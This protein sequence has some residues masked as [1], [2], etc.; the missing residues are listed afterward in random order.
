[1]NGGDERRNEKRLHCD[2]VIWLTD[3]NNKKRYHGMIHDLSSSGVA[4]I[5]NAGDSFPQQGQQIQVYFYIPRIESGEPY[6]VDRRGNVCR[7]I[8]LDKFVRKVHV[9]FDVPLSFKPTELK[10]IAVTLNDNDD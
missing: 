10:A 4:F 9:K 2:W 6:K 7:V 1:M 3:E 5:C 8:K